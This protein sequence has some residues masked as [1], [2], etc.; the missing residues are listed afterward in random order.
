MGVCKGDSFAERMASSS[1]VEIEK[2]KG[3]NFE[4]W[5]LKMEYLLVDKEKW[6]VVDP[7]TKPIGMST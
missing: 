4:L 2:F 1:R 5:K 7:G 6:V 3:H